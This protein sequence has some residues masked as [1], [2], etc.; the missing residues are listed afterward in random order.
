MAWRNSI[1]LL[2][3]A[4]MTLSAWS[5]PAVAADVAAEP[6]QKKRK[7]FGR[8]SKFDQYWLFGDPYECPG[9]ETVPAC[10]AGNVVSAALRFANRAEPSYRVPRVT[11]LTPV[12]ELNETY[13]N[14]SPLVR[15]YCLAS[16]SLDNGDHATAH[17]FVEED[18]GFVG[19]S[20]SVYV[21]I[22]GYDKWRVYDGRCRVARPA[23]VN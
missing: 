19:L 4:V 17:Y 7:L 10:D 1:N 18:G 12:R 8:C 11:S 13:L 3:A 5:L 16:V 6:I 23:T 9:D 14:P 21:C 22:I 20:W 2:I 15:R